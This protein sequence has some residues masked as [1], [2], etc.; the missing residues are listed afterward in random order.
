MFGK[1]GERRAGRWIINAYQRGGRTRARLVV[2]EF[3]RSVRTYIVGG[4]LL[5]ELVTDSTGLKQFPS[6]SGL[7]CLSMVLLLH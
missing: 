4:F 6:L 3:Q 7:V 2:T 5:V 1:R